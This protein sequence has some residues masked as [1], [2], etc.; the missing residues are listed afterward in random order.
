MMLSHDI[1]EEK[2]DDI[3]SKKSPINDKEISKILKNKKI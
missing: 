2:V 1:C 3:N